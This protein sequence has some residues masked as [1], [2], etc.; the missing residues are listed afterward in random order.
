[1]QRVWAA[2]CGAAA[3]PSAWTTLK[4]AWAGARAAKRRGRYRGWAADLARHG[5]PADGMVRLI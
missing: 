1:M 2:F 5:V 4:T 3:E